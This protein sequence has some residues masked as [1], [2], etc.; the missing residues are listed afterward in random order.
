[1]QR[2]QVRRC[3]VLLTFEKLMK[4]ADFKTGRFQAR[5]RGNE[6]SMLATFI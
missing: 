1:M 6:S 3:S 5:L 2:S 4:W